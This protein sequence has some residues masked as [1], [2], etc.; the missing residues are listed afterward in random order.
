MRGGGAHEL[1]ELVGQAFVSFAHAFVRAL[2]GGL[3]ASQVLSDGVVDALPT[4]ALLALLHSFALVLPG[5]SPQPLLGLPALLGLRVAF[6]LVEVVDGVYC[7]GLLLSFHLE[8][9]RATLVS[10]QQVL[11]ATT[12]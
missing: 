3:Y 11:A 8:S 5:D 6:L 12:K 2:I 7:A 9:K 10:A 4:V 1:F